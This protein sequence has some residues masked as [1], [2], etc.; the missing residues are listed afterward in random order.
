M[1]VQGGRGGADDLV[2]RGHLLLAPGLRLSGLA[3][4]ASR[5]CLAQ[6][7]IDRRDQPAKLALEQVVV[8]TRSH[9][10]H[11]GFL[12]DGAGNHD[13]GDVEAARL[14][15]FQSR[16]RTEPR[17]AVVAENQIPRSLRQGIPHG[18]GGIHPAVV[19]REPGLREM[20]DQQ[21]GIALYVL[22][23]EDAQR[24]L[25]CIRH[26]SHRFKPRAAAG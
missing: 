4:L 5:D 21:V 11:R 14:V 22:D 23:Q 3:V 16:G 1:Q 19:D 17:H 9:H 2:D 25:G 18:L 10:G 12:A 8:R 24:F 26:R 6:L 7:A 15:D 20:A 13:E